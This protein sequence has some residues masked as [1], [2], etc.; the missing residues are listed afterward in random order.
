MP[1][2]GDEYLLYQTLIGAWPIE[3]ARA[4]EYMTKAA[5]E[6]KL[7]TSW[8]APDEDYDAALERFV[9]AVLTDDGFVAELEEFVAP[10]VEPGRIASLSQTLIK[11]TAP[12]V[13]DIYQGCECWDLSLV[14]PDNRRPVDFDR[15]SA[16]LESIKRGDLKGA[17]DEPKLRVIERAL[18]L[19]ARRP[20][21]FGE[22]ATY[23]ALRAR[24]S[25]SERVVAFS[26]SSE[27]VTVAPRLTFGLG[28]MSGTTV[29][30]PAGFWSDQFTGRRYSGE[31][32]L[33]ELWGDFPVCLLTRGSR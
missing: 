29:E 30:L 16:L 26:R 22:R 21:L 7:H 25:N 10:L 9:G 19:R 13:P 17:E 24:G 15:R 1:S 32:G 5:K 6:A 12:G 11:L 33:D 3:A 4:E 2:R 14:D 20:E 23:E 18:A 27:V 31:T 8:I 28:D